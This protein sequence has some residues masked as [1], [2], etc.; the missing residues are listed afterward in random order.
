MF[1][2]HF[3]LPA[4]LFMMPYKKTEKP[5]EEIP[6]GYYKCIDCG[7]ICK[8]TSSSQIRCIEC[9]KVHSRMLDRQRKKNKK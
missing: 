8:R 6:K 5:K 9:Q 4:L 2:I 7:A 1:F 3:I